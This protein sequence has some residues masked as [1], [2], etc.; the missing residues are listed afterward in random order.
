M[1]QVIFWILGGATALPV[2]LWLVSY[3]ISQGW[4]AGKFIQLNRWTHKKED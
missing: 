1:W 3:V 4:H 2:V